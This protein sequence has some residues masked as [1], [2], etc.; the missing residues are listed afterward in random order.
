VSPAASL[1]LHL[2]APLA[3][4]IEQAGATAYPNECCGI[5]YGRDTQT[6]R[7]VETLEPVDN[8]FDTGEQ[9]HRFSISA[10]Q[11]M[12]AEKNASDQG[13]L[14]LGFY[15]SH[16]DHPARP[17]E[18][19]REHAWPFYSYIIVSI[20]KRDPVD[21]TSWLLNAST[22]TFSRQD[23]VEVECPTPNKDH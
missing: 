15:H 10:R 23:I 1:P 22:E 17:S 4:Q 16:P 6:A 12:A 7:I 9:Y 20:A 14:V 2:P 5:L 19:D 21:M 8:S 3:R 11:L 13:R 18:Y